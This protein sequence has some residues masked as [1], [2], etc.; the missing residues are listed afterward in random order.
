MQCQKVGPRSHIPSLFVLGG[1][2]SRHNAAGTLG[3]LAGLLHL[4]VHPPNDYSGNVSI[5]V[6]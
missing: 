6:L 4:G 5:M 2:A 1:M 3:I